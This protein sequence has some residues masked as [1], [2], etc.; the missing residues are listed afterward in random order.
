MKKQAT[1][2]G[3]TAEN[4]LYDQS[5]LSFE[6]ISTQTEGLSQ[7]VP[8]ISCIVCIRECLLYPHSQREM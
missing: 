7:I 4:S 5:L 6:G 8:S 1:I 2:P 3:F